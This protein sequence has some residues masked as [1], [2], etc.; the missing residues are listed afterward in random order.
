MLAFLLS[1]ISSG[2][3]VIYGILTA[4]AAVAAAL[5]LG[6]RQ[7][8]REEQSRA[9]IEQL[10]RSNEV[11]QSRTAIN[12]RTA[13]LSDDELDSLQ[14]R[15]ERDEAVAPELRGVGSDSDEPQRR[16]E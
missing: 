2:S 8:R 5:F 7:G 11:L 6:K 1:L 3:T 15:Y 13:D 12:S 4:A 14:Q 10:E 9:R 16:A